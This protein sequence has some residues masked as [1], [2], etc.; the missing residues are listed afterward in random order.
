[1]SGAGGQS[2]S[3]RFEDERDK[4]ANI[5]AAQISVPVAHEVEKN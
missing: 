5:A 2:D 3:D 1:M 4:G